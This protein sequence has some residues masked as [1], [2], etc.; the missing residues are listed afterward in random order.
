M[1]PLSMLPVFSLV[2]QLGRQPT[3]PLR[4]WLR[5]TGNKLRPPRTVPHQA[6]VRTRQDFVQ[7]NGHAGLHQHADVLVEKRP[8]PCPTI[9][10][11]GF[12]P[13]STDAFYLMRGGLTA[14][15]S[16]YYLNYPSR[17]FSTELF[18]AQL[19][20]LIEEIARTRGH[21]PALIGVSFGAGLVL[22][23]LR[24][25]AANGR[26]L[27]LAGLIL[28]SP[29]ACAADL[30]DPDELKPSTLLGRVIKPYLSV[31]ARSDDSV[32][33]KAR[34]VFLKMFESGANNRD[35]LRFVLTRLESLRLRD[36]V[37]GTIN[38]INATGAGERVRALAAMP[39]MREP[40]VF[41]SGPTLVL[42]AEKET[43]VLVRTSPTWR[44]FRQRS[45]AWFPRGRCVTVT[46]TS[47]NPVQHAS[48]IF[49]SH[50]FQ[51]HFTAFYRRLRYA[52]AQAA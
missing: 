45:S 1:P 39:A 13:D 28:V 34:S 22:E 24:Q 2:A 31:P 20:D 23:L 41:F 47:D 6:T 42:Y 30:L 21:R 35:A 11:G 3:A 51:P 52:L 12:V 27:P 17:G 5:T 32:V 19:E 50:N 33:E 26:E 48:L 8:G 14:H 7:A 37:L 9:I 46:N 16:V 15:G 43:S 38:A 4:I 29:V 40:T 18:L 25:A 49:H 44:E 36:S 10:V